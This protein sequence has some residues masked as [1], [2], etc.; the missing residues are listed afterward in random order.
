MATFDISAINTAFSA[1]NEVFKKRVLQWDLASLGIQIR[2]NVKAP[3]NMTK[4]S[5]D[6]EPRPYRAQDDYNGATFTDRTLTVYQSKYDLQLD[7][8]ELRNT[9]LAVLPEMPFEQYVL[10]QA[11]DQF[12]SK[13]QS[14]TLYLGVRN[15]GGNAAVDIVDGWGTILAADIISTDFPAAQVVATGAVTAANAVTKVEE[16]ADACTVMM[17]KAGFRILCSYDVLSKYR[18]H[19]R[20]LNGFGFNKNETGQYQLDGMNAVLQ[21][22]AFL[23]T[24]QRLIATLDNNLVLGTDTDNVS[25]FATPHLNLMQARIMFP[26][27]CQFRDYDVMYVNDQV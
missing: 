16:V 26:V 12:M 8:E 13:L 7:S 11:I 19:Y 4:L 5:A 25:T 21:P 1:G 22:A 9:Y 10:S 20:T 17:K 18:I 14:D 15:A 6:G 27:G 23:G 2:T 24:S 3:Q